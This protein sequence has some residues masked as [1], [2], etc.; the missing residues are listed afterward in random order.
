MDHD[1]FDCVCGQG[2]TVA[3]YGGPNPCPK[4]P[5]VWDYD[6]GQA[7]TPES[8]RAAIHAAV[9][10]ERKRCITIIEQSGTGWNP[11]TPD[12]MRAKLIAAIRDVEPGSPG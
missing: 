9:A 6:E 10:A 12:G 4:C 8:I 7:A 2:M 3:R 5:L 11:V 1:P